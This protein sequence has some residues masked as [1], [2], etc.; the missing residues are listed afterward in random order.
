MKSKIFIPVLS[1]FA[2]GLTFMSVNGSSNSQS[3]FA[4]DDNIAQAQSCYT[5]RPY[6]H[7]RCPLPGNQ[8]VFD[9]VADFSNGPC[10][11]NNN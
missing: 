8:A 2:L 4:S 1:V 3:M 10:P 11:G 6:I 7:K 9:Y 5:C